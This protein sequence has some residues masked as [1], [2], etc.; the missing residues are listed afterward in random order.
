MLIP[1]GDPHPKTDVL[2]GY[3][4][5]EHCASQRSSSLLPLHP[6]FDACPVLSHTF[7]G[8]L[9]DLTLRSQYLTG[10]ALSRVDLTCTV[11]VPGRSESRQGSSD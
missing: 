2:L 9:A 7:L 10:G 3:E 8:R 11:I 4:T 1:E 5:L 6:F